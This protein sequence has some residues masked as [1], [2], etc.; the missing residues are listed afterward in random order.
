V[1]LT[2]FQPF[3]ARPKKRPASVEIEKIGCAI[4]KLRTK[5]LGEPLERNYVG[6]CKALGH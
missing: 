5:V 1:T 6:G 4:W 3:L 2:N